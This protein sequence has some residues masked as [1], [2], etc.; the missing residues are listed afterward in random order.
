MVQTAV[1][2][3]V[4]PAVAA[5]NPHGLLAQMLGIALYVVECFLGVLRH[6]CTGHS[7]LQRIADGLDL[8]TDVE[9]IVPCLRRS[10]QVA[11]LVDL[12]HQLLDLGAERGALLLDREADA[13]TELGVVL[14]QGAA[15]RGAEAL[16]VGAVGEAG[17]AGRP[18]LGAAG[19]GGNVHMV[20]EQLGNELGVRRLAA[21][22]AG[23]VEL[24]QG[25][26]ELAALDGV[27]AV[28]VA[29]L[30]QRVDVLPVGFLVALSVQRLH[31]DSLG[32]ADRHAAAAALAVEDGAL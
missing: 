5:E 6:F 30:R 20:A 16:L 29:H 2:D 13:H 22:C 26:V 7:R 11:V 9:V 28:G 1:A 31:R 15:Q 18:D 14:K 10:I 19:G 12:A 21:A 4:G 32:R 27:I 25:L 24:Q 23:A 8:G 17:E 3:I